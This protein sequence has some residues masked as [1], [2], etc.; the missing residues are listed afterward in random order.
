MVCGGCSG[1][2]GVEAHATCRVEQFFFDG[3]GGKVATWNPESVFSIMPHTHKWSIP[4]RYRVEVKQAMSLPM[5][6]LIVAPTS[7]ATSAFSIFL[8]GS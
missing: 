5:L 1:S 8:R 7:Y 6:L 2:W 4:C 3:E